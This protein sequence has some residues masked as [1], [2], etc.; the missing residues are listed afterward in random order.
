MNTP[1]QG[2]AADLLKLAAFD[3]P[4]LADWRRLRQVAHDARLRATSLLLPWWR[5]NSSCVGITL[6][7]WAKLVFVLVPVKLKS[8]TPTESS[9]MI[10]RLICL[11]LKTLTRPPTPLYLKISCF[12]HR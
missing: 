8:R 7:V 3:A 2:T 1:I 6:A 4:E 12:A 9:R 11:L 5:R 10:R